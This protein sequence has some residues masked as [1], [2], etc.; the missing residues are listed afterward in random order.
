MTVLVA[1]SGTGAV[2]WPLLGCLEPRALN[3]C[4]AQHGHDVRMMTT[5]P[6]PRIVAPEMPATRLPIGRQPTSRQFHVADQLVHLDGDPLI[7]A[8][9]QQ[10]RQRQRLAKQARVRTPCTNSPR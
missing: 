10:D 9:H 5:E 6:S 8:T 4:G 3:S 1:F 7:T 2:S